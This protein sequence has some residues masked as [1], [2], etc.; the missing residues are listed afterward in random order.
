M[1][2]V[3]KP[4]MNQNKDM[5]RWIKV[6]HAGQNFV[7]LTDPTDVWCSDTIKQTFESK[8][9][10][11][12]FKFD[13]VH[14]GNDSPAKLIPNIKN[15][16]QAI[17]FLGYKEDG[18][19]KVGVWSCSK[20][21]HNSIVE[22]SIQWGT[23]LGKGIRIYKSNNRWGVMVAPSEV[24]SPAILDELMKKVPQ[25]DEEAAQYLGNYPSNEAIWEALRKQLNVESNEEVE[26][27]FKGEKKKPEKKIELT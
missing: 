10:P 27:I 12:N 6:D 22:Q 8:G 20:T 16:Y 3:A 24:P 25:T 21:V 14:G 2:K 7:L 17:F 23:L 15:S 18:E 26:A 13:D 5:I 1:K 11:I 9:Y 19:W 4:E